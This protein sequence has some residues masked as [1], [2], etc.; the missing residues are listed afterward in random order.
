LAIYDDGNR[1]GFV[2]KKGNI[3]IP[4]KFWKVYNFSEGVA[5]VCLQEHKMCGYINH[6]GKFVIAPMFD[7]VYKFKNSKAKVYY[8]GK[9]FLIDKQG[10]I[11]K[12]I[13]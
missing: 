11:I 6:K 3:V 10:N 1:F 12:E 2:N 7:D 9:Y 13:L 4:A 5:G 8:K